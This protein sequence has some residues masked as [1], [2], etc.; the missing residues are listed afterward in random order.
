MFSD[1]MGVLLCFLKCSKAFLSV[2]SSFERFLNVLRC[3][4]IFSDVL[5]CSLVF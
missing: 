3:T 1:V 4:L 2:C 5:L